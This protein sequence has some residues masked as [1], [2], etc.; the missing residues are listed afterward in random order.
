M[1]RKIFIVDTNV[2]V[3]ALISSYPDSPPVR[4]SRRRSYQGRKINR[5]PRPQPGQLA[6]VS[7]RY[8]QMR[9]QVAGLEPSASVHP[10]TLTPIQ[11][12]WL[13]IRQL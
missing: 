12:S 3:S 13:P 6:V 11:D 1:A 9:A 5:Y 8:T 7:I 2:V 10:G 4:L